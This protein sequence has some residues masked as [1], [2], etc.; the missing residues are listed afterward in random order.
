MNA[1]PPLTSVWFDGKSARAR[2]CTLRLE[3]NELVL[4]TENE[5]RRYATAQVRWPERL[6]HG[7]R[8][9]DLPDGG[10]IQHADGS[11]WDAWW[12]S[13]G[14]RETIVVGWMQ[15]WRATLAALVGTAL[16]V[17]AAWWWG[18][19]ALGRGMAHLAPPA[20]EA[21]IGQQAMQ[22]LERLYLAPS[23]LPQHERDELH[24]RVGSLVDRAWT[25]GE[26]PA[27]QLSFHH[28]PALGANAFALPGGQILVTDDLVKLLRDEPDAILG[29]VAHELGHVQHR[30]GLDLLVRTSLVSGIV[31]VVLGDAGAFVAALPATLATQAYSRDA[32]RRADLHAANMLHRSGISPAVMVT[33]FQRM[34]TT[35]GSN[36]GKLPIAIASHPHHEE[37][38]RFFREWRD[39]P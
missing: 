32:E 15:S 3:R 20:L 6:A 27:W 5:E 2:V 14:Q 1:S 30:D 26:A 24:R 37:R 38:I 11:E 35:S 4:H 9:A 16:L 19:P 25:L 7:R 23:Q 28:A 36:G 22:H 21:H 33:F 17:A 18:L 10:L 12:R 29:V 13:S 34:Q 39:E 31:G 8:Q